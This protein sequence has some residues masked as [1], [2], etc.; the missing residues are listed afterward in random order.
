MIRISAVTA[1]VLLIGP[2]ALADFP[3]RSSTNKEWLPAVAY[4]ST[5]HEYLVVWSE[6]MYPSM[7]GVNGVRGQRLGE[8]G[9]MI[10]SSFQVYP[11]GVSAAVAYNSAANEYLVAFNPGSGYAGQRVSNTGTPIGD[12]TG[13]MDGVSN[14]RL[15]YNSITGQYLI[16]GAV[17]VETPTGS[18]YYNIK[19][20]SRKIGADGQAVAAAVLVDN[21][22]HGY[23]PPEPA[24]GAAF[25]PVQSTETPYGR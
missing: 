11:Y 4:N 18:G 6:E 7:P 25:A 9:N 20:S 14:A 1:L 8:D 16:I 15:L 21:V 3:V 22:P 12:P 10:G 19:I 17:L 23:Q 5:D 24:F 2:F 13:L